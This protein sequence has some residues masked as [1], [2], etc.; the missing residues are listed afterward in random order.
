[1]SATPSSPEH[2][3]SVEL[4][5]ERATLSFRRF[6]PHPPTD[7]WAALT[8]PAQLE[9]WSMTKGTVDGRPGGSID[10]ISGPSRF[11][12]TGRILHWDPPRVFEYEW[13]VAPRTEL[14]HGEDAVVRWEL[15]PEGAGTRLSVTYRGLHRRT[16]LGFAPGLHAFLDRLDAQLDERPLPNWIQRVDEL[17]PRYPPWET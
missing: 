15:V 11:H 16:G 6:F 3:G 12:V 4:D 2:L 14:P 9:E 7:V 8:E 5:A 1:M 10:F 17:R 13:K